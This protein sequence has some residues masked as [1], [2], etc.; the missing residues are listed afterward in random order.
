MPEYDHLV[1][2]GAI[3]LEKINLSVR[4]PYRQFYAIKW[5]RVTAPMSQLGLMT[6]M[7][8]PY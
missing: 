5:D 8:Q 3:I 1:K 2:A 7:I 4:I 6:R